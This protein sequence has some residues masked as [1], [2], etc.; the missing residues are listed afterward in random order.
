MITLSK[1]RKNILVN[2]IKNNGVKGVVNLGLFFFEKWK[3]PDKVSYN[4]PSITFE[5]TTFCNL[6]C[7]MCANP[8]LGKNRGNFNLDKFKEFVD[9]NNYIKKINLTGLGETLMN[10]NLIEMIKYSKR[11]GIYAWFVNN[12]TLMKKD[13]G[14]KLLDSKVDLICISIDGA[15]KETFEKIRIGAKFEDV[16]DN[17]KKFL[18]L[19][20]G[21]S[22]TQV[23][24]NMVVTKENYKEIEGLI[25]IAHELRIDHLTF[26]TA[27]LRSDNMK[28]LSFDSVSREDLEVVLKR[29]K[30]TARELGVN[31]LTWPIVRKPSKHYCPM[32]W[33]NPYVAYNGD[34]F[35]CCFV[36][37]EVEGRTRD[38]NIMGNVYKEDFKVIW[39]GE[40][41]K[42]FRNRVKTKNPP[43]S[44]LTCPSYHGLW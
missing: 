15:T 41:Y 30:K 12:M 17:T 18:E 38:E 34:V 29:A 3:K 2:T 24:I 26:K 9:S 19:R 43:K 35:P 31:V 16:I 36:L 37:Q 21:N 7:T 6:K 10:P 44:C 25:K 33:E 11:K 39:N 4:P 1:N 20:N 28:T 8:S 5:V 42:S 40:K 13:I 22:S 14:Q 23:G 32:P 27:Y